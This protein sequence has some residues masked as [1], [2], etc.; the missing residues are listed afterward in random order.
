MPRRDLPSVIE[1][2]LSKSPIFTPAA[3]EVLALARDEAN[4]MQHTAVFTQH[5]LLGCL[6]FGK[7]QTAKVFQDH[8]IDLEGTRIEFLRLVDPGPEPVSAEI[9]PYSP[10]V[11]AVMSAAMKEAEAVGRPYV[12]PEHILLALL[13]E[14]DGVV[15]RVLKNL[16]ADAAKLHQEL[17][18]L[19]ET[20]LR[21]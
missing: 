14:A 4:R 13:S 19:S 9:I 20:R 5:L 15:L 1:S 8:G 7:G 11:L 6:R 3:Q 18:D 12:G 16:N 17:L 10:K 21:R 2:M